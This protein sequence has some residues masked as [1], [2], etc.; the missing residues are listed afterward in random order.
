M[1]TV[2]FTGAT[3]GLGMACVQLLSH[4]GWTVFAAGTNEEKL[5]E[6]GKLPHVI[7]VKADV[8]GDASMAAARDTVTQHTDSLQAVVNFAGLT[9]FGALTEGDTVN[10]CE[11]LLYVNV[12][13]TVRTNRLFFDMLVRGKGRIVNC[14]SSAGWMTPQPFAGAYTM[15][16]YAVEAYNDSLRR[17]AM[18]MGVPVIKL[19]PGAFKTNMMGEIAADFEHALADTTFY[20][21]LLNTM[22]PLMDITLSRPGNPDRLARVVLRALNDQKPKR[23]YRIGTSLP[24]LLLEL[25]P[26]G[27]ADAAYR[28][29]YG[30]SKGKNQN[31]INS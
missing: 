1:R 20:Q 25:L 7:P 11:K 9:A 10:V 24:L 18:Y 4:S 31:K 21:G 12:L 17:E 27:G 29:L 2:F 26:E 30:Y 13:G 6:L 16:K 19:Q 23:Q 3:G 22:R 8:T 15:S 5:A 28:L 14:S